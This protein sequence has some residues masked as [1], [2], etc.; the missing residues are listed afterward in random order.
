MRGRVGDGRD[1]L[2]NQPVLESRIAVSHSRP[3]AA[4]NSK[5]A[6]ASGRT[7][8]RYSCFAAFKMDLAKLCL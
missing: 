3:R 7:C 4:A 1:A 2:S 6:G 5:S 8:S